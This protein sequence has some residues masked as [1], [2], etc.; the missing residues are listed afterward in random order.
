MVTLS[1]ART[2]TLVY[3][4][5]PCCNAVSV[6]LPQIH[7]YELHLYSY[8]ERQTHKTHQIPIL[9]QHNLDEWPYNNKTEPE[10]SFVISGFRY[11]FWLLGK[12]FLKPID[13]SSGHESCSVNKKYS[14]T[15]GS[16]RLTGSQKI[17]QIRN[18]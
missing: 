17:F 14:N 6:P 8:H 4:Y 3:F 13:I 5:H 16:D 9:S 15:I 2:T 11:R 12:D 7:M 1:V 18:S 10:D